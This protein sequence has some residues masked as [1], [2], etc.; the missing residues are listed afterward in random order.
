[1]DKK[2][3]LRI[4]LSMTCLVLVGIL[5]VVFSVLYILT[6]KDGFLYFNKK[7]I[8]LAIVC[9]VSIIIIL[10]TIFTVK[11]T[12]FIYKISIC[13]LVLVFIAVLTLY[14]L[15]ITGILNKISTI[16]AL[17]NYVAS[18]GSLATIIYIIVNFLQVIILPI[19]GFVSVL[20][21]V[22]LFGPLKA[23]IYSLIGI[24]LGSFVAF[25]IGRVFG[26]KVVKWLIGEETTKTWLT[27]I[28]NKDKIILSFMF[29]FPF[30]P[31]DVLCFVA[32]LSSMST[33][34]YAVMILICRSIS[35]FI[36]SYSV[37]GNLI[38]YTTWWGILI[39]ALIFIFTIFIAVII[40]KNGDKLQ[41]LL[42]KRK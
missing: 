26:Y 2:S 29:L 17:R 22:A 41:K 3:L 5:T 28:K 12:F 39:W 7:I 35:V 34:Y 42:V 30:F 21:G 4:C 36:S 37:S 19:P 11:D 13:T 9:S 8:I 32:G 24:L 23:S 33:L 1:M 31:D 20:S 25:F 40:Y 10:S 27:K 16:T 18:F 14:I 15:K 6:C 38:P